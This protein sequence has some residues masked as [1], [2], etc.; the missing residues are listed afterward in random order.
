[1]NCLSPTLYAGL[2]FQNSRWSLQSSEEGGHNR[3]KRSRWTVLIRSDTNDLDCRGSG[4]LLS[5]SSPSRCEHVLQVLLLQS[6]NI[7]SI[8]AELQSLRNLTELDLSQ[9]HFTQV[10]R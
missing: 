6:N 10:H 8:S 7:S 2:C 3:I 4:S 5:S 9:N 1:M